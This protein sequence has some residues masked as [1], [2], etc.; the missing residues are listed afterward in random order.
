[1]S[2]SSWH[3]PSLLFRQR[4]FL[5]MLAGAI[6]LRDAFLGIAFFAVLLAVHGKMGSARTVLLFVFFM[7]GLGAVFFAVPAA[8]ECP[9]WAFPGK[10]V[11]IEGNIVS[12]SG[13]PGRRVRILLENVHPSEYMPDLEEG[14]RERIRRILEKKAPAWPFT[15]EK[16]YP[17]TLVEDFSSPFR[18]L[19]SLTLYPEDI[20]SCGRPV[21][22]QKVQ[23]VVRLYPISG[24]INEG[25]GDGRNYWKARNVWLNA[26]LS[27]VGNTPVFFKL[28]EG[29]GIGYRLSLLR[30]RWQMALEEMLFS[31]RALD[32][33]KEGELA[34]NEKINVSR[35]NT[36]SQG[37][38]LLPAL[39][40][41]DRFWLDPE[42]VDIFAKAGLAHS[43]AL[44]GQHLSLVVIAGSI[45]IFLLSLAAGSVFLS[46]PRRICCAAV[47][48][49]LAAGYLFL[50]G[51]PFSLV[52]AAVMMAVAAAF[53]CARR[54]SAPMD[55]LFAAAFFLF[56]GWPLSVYDL[57][58]ELSI[59]AVGGIILS[60]PLAAVGEKKLFSL[61]EQRQNLRPL[62]ACLKFFL[63]WAWRLIFF[64]LAAQLAVLPVLVTVFGAV[65]MNIW[66]NLLWIPLLSLVILPCAALGLTG[67]IFLGSQAVS[68]LLL[69]AAAWPA[70]KILSFLFLMDKEGWLPLIQCFRPSSLSWLGYGA[71]LVGGILWLEGRISGRGAGRKIWVLI[72]CGGFLL[73]VEQAS[74]WLK[75][76]QKKSMRAVSLS[77]IDVGQGQSV[78]LEAGGKRILVDGGGS[79]SPFFDCGKSILAPVLTYGRMPRLDAVVVSHTDTD[80]A[81]GLRWILE[82]FEVSCLCWSSFSARDD[83]PEARE[84][85]RI[86]QRRGIAEKILCPGDRIMLEEGIE[87]EVVWPDEDAI[88]PAKRS[89]KISGNAA[90]L[91]LRL[92]RDGTGLALLCGDMTAGSLRRLAESGRNLSAELLVLPHH[93]AS[94][95]LQKSF[96]DAVSPDVALA[97]AAAFNQ[98]GFPSRAV[99]EEMKKR[100]VPLYSTAAYG[101][102]TV[103]WSGKDGRRYFLHPAKDKFSILDWIAENN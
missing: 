65:S 42:T 54:S 5:A 33:A 101:G 40:F 8:P 18:A 14:E 98:Y 67:L 103:V 35:S 47:G 100:N 15:G 7:L 27:R 12:V 6:F 71:V 87:L 56:L 30:F 24:S 57:S 58:A 72:L 13:L 68:T 79:S 99:R 70:E 9:S 29:E 85:R 25:S 62:T 59:L 92:V 76:F 66:A 86:V 45:F 34:L 38:A 22:G 2:G 43:L 23:G 37:K 36:I 61:Q 74:V 102:L 88:H 90:S 31:E 63:L 1:M 11:F 95:S 96:Y 80:H 82:H 69:D 53:L 97:S 21:S 51:A 84:L 46:F 94:S 26:R 89:G 16:E 83:S 10:H 19:I 60:L 64:S 73:P 32:A 75:D 39:L 28:E 48:I 50:G 17:G 93:G 41:G 52:R 49:P 3:H 78:L 77:M 44:S 55:I 20:K 91:A 4:L 81:R